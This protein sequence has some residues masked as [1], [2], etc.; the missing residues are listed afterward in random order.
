SVRIGSIDSSDDAQLL[1]A[2]SRA[3]FADGYLLYVRAG[4]LFAQPFNP[5]RRM[6]VGEPLRIVE[7]MYAT[8][9]GLAA[10]EFS[11]SAGV[12]SYRTSMPGGA[13]SQLAWFDRSGREISRLGE[14]A[15]Q[16]GVEL[17]PDGSRVAIS[18]LDAARPTRDLWIYDT[19]KSSPVR[20]TFDEA[21]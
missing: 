1:A 16:T 7:N 8:P 13:A 21:D 11:A 4:A 17:S 6:I 5:E 2:D 14:R 18:I 20:L 9:G 3:I 15:D 12:L 19:T 10:G